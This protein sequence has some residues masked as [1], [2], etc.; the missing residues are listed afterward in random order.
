MDAMTAISLVSSLIS[1]VDLG[2]KIVTDTYEVYRS[3]TGATAGNAHIDTVISDL[4]ALTV[5]LEA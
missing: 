4:Q 5:D 1:F 2:T 3:S